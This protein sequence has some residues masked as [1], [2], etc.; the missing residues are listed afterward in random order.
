[1]KRLPSGTDGT[2][3]RRRKRAAVDSKDNPGLALYVLHA[4]QRANEGKEM[5][6]NLEREPIL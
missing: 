6:T 3:I 5:K 4:R 1:V 2:T